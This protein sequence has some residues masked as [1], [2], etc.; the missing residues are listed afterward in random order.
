MI[1]IISKNDFPHENNRWLLKNCINKTT[2][3]M[4]R[5]TFYSKKDLFIGIMLWLPPLVLF[6]FSVVY[7]LWLGLLISILT[8]AIIAFLWFGIKYII[9]GDWLSV[10]IG[11]YLYAKIKLEDIS[12]A[13]DTTD[14]VA[15]PALSFD[16][17]ALTFRNNNY[18]VV[19]PDH[20]DEFLKA[21]GLNKP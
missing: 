3:Q 6:T 4:S 9:E 12:S 10:Y 13:K 5:M 21:L 1:K 16:R 7:L 18:L 11:P 19:S 17:L 8:L 15:S 20:K 14:P 2:N